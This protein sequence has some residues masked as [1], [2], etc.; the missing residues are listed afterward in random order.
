MKVLL[1]TDFSNYACEAHKY[2]FNLLQPQ[3]ASYFLVH[4]ETSQQ[5]ENT[6]KIASDLLISDKFDNAYQQLTNFLPKGNTLSR[7]E[8]KGNLLD[9]VRT[10]IDLLEID[11]VVMGAKGTSATSDKSIGKNTYEIATKVKCPVLIVPENTKKNPPSRVNFPVDYKDKLHSK[12]ISKI[13]SLPNWAE[14][15]ITIHELN[16]TSNGAFQQ[17][18]SQVLT[19]NLKMVKPKFIQIDEINFAKLTKEADL[20]FLAA[21]NLG[22]CSTVFKQL[23]YS[24]NGSVKPIP[25]LILHA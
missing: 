21:K 10:N 25:M 14:M 16:A 24:V 5:T 1:L 13:Q 20:I 2:A 22:V 8:R 15:N 18:S 17:E 9:V 11:L 23:N 19:E 6:N 12:C 4:A 3:Q 7:L